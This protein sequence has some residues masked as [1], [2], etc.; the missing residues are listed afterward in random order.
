MIT[1]GALEVTDKLKWT[2]SG[3][4]LFSLHHGD[5]TISVANVK[6]DMLERVWK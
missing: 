1:H 2:F 6:L 4:N 5:S 3:R